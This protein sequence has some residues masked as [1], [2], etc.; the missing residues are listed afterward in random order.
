M[1]AFTGSSPAWIPWNNGAHA[2]VAYPANYTDTAFPEFVDRFPDALP[3][4]YIRARLGANGV[5]TDGA[6]V[7]P[8]N[9]IPAYDR[10]QLEPYSFPKLPMG[11][12]TG[13]APPGGVFAVYAAE[14]FG[15][16]ADTRTPRQKDG[17]LLIS[18]GIDRLYGTTDDITSAG[19]IK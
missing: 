8:A 19:K 10:R 5:V 16:I 9:S 15:N 4:L 14:Y 13:N 6:T 3:I 2:N 11:P 7:Y 1:L 17:Y 12:P 18:A